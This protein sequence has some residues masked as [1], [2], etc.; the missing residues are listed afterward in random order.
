MKARWWRTRGSGWS[1]AVDETFLSTLARRRSRSRPGR[2]RRRMRTVGTGEF[3]FWWF[4]PHGP[5]GAPVSRS[6]T[7]ARL[8]LGEHA[9]QVLGDCGE[10]QRGEVTA[11]LLNRGWPGASHR[12]GR[13][14]G[15]GS[16]SCG[17]FL[18]VAAR[19]YFARSITTSS[20]TASVRC[21][22]RRLLGCRECGRA[23]WDR[24]FAAVRS[25]GVVAYQDEL[26]EGDPRG[27]G[28]GPSPQRRRVRARGGRSRSRCWW[29]HRRALTESLG[30]GDVG[31]G[32]SGG[33]E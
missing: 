28:R 29:R 9:G 11:Q 4:R 12:R 6:S 31:A 5:A 3:A 15:Q 30:H 16:R 7:T 2:G 19:S 17:V 33:T 13:R 24:S 32:R 27:R 10:L 18:P 26:L 25:G 8:R 14:H 22:R 20:L 1:R 21:W 23:R